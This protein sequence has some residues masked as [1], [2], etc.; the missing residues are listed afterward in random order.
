[1]ILK[2]AIGSC[3]FEYRHERE[4]LLVLNY[5]KARFSPYNNGV[6]LLPIVTMGNICYY[7][8]KYIGYNDYKIPGS[9]SNTGWSMVT[10]SKFMIAVVLI[11]AILL[12]FPTISTAAIDPETVVT[13]KCTACHM[14]DRIREAKKSKTEWSKLVKKEI[15]RGASLTDAERDAVIGWLAE[16]YGVGEVAQTTPVQQAEP[17]PTQ[18]TQTEPAVAAPSAAAPAQELPFDEQAETGVELWQLVLSGGALISGGTWL[19]RR[20]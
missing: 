15:E 2:R 11:T 3:Y 19:R 10:K 6:E 20:R 7:A 12:L 18:S 9:E 8:F 4:K 17:E 14:A 1:M 5:K 13:G 16:N